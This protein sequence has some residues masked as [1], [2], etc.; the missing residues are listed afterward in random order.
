[1]DPRFVIDN[2]ADQTLGVGITNLSNIGFVVGHGVT[3]TL[4]SIDV[5]GNDGT[6]N[7]FTGHLKGI[8]TGVR[9]DTCQWS[10]RR[11]ILES[12]PEFRMLEQ[13]STSNTLKETITIF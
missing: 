3:S 12:L 5:P 2:A 4:T 11:S 6:V 10:L 7:T 1:M 13:S 9:T 8:I